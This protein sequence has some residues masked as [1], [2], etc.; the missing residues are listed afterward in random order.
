MSYKKIILLFLVIPLLRFE[1]F[2]QNTAPNEFGKICPQV[3]LIGSSDLNFL[4]LKVYKISLW[5]EDKKFSY[6]KKFAIEILYNMN[7]SKEDLAK[8]SIEEI[9][10]T[11]S[12]SQEEEETYYQKLISIFSNIKKGDQKLAIFDPKNGV[13]LFHNHNL[14]GDIS[15]LKFARLFVDIWLNENGSY[16]KVTKKILGK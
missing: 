4:A 1:A 7:F 8:R 9:K 13:K 11:T 2:A 12:I 14:K 6:D 10:K 5:S 3:Y 16:P 15:D